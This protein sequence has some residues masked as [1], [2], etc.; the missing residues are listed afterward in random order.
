MS[1]DSKGWFSNVEPS[2]AVAIVGIILGPFLTGF[3]PSYIAI[4][5][6]LASTGVKIKTTRDRVDSIERDVEQNEEDIEK[7]SNIQARLSSI[8]QQ[9]ESI[10]KNLTRIRDDQDGRN[11]TIR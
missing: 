9:I 11:R 6:N 10:E 7:I 2:H 5:T 1:P 4:K 8:E 3:V